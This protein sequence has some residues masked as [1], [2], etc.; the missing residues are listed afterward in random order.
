M[1]TAS[2]HFNTF[3]EMSALKEVCRDIAGSL[4]I[5]ESYWKFHIFNG[6]PRMCIDFAWGTGFTIDQLNVLTANY[7][8]H[9]T[10]ILT[11]VG[12]FQIFLARHPQADMIRDETRERH[13]AHCEGC[14]DC[15][16]P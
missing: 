2:K 4:N 8:E 3:F 5:D 15:C 16:T 6:V 10:G 7:S 13:A 1:T 12:E 14:V 11:S 9:I